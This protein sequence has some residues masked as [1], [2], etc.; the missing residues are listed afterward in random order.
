MNNEKLGETLSRI[1]FEKKI[2]PTEL[3]RLTDVP[4]P[5]IQRIVAGTTSRPHISSLEPIAKHFSIDVDQLRGL[6][7]I[8]WLEKSAAKKRD[9][10]LRDMPVLSWDSVTEWLENS[11]TSSTEIL[12]TDAEVSEKSFALKIKDASMEPQFPVN[13][14]IIV[15]PEKETKDRRFV[16]VKIHDR[17]EVIFRQLVIDAGR[18]FIKALSP[19]LEQFRIHLLGDNDKIC[20]VLAQARFDYGD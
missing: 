10:T 16:I 18:Y 19:D 8:P 13:T 2:K 11:A 5:T 7:P 9:K 3:A 6:K 17:S 14:T 20:G 12:T 15:D 1:L 4:Q